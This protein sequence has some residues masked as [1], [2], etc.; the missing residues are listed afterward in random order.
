M[1]INWDGVNHNKI[2]FFGN[3]FLLFGFF[4][5]ANFKGIS[6]F[7]FLTGAD[8]GCFLAIFQIF[9]RLLTFTF[10]QA[11]EG[12]EIWFLPNSSLP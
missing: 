5:F 4:F 8:E 6:C 1:D 11:H 12:R 2:M 3:F 9:Y 10:T 7:F